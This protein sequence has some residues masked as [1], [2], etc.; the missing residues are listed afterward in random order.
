MKIYQV[1]GCVRD[2]LLGKASK[3]RDWVVVGATSEQMLALG[4]IQVGKDFPVFLHPK[5][6]EEYALARTERKT[7]KGYTGF[8]VHAAPEVTLEEDL[9]R[10]DLTIN[11]IATDETGNLIDPFNGQ[12]DLQAGILRHVSNAFV[13]DPVRVLRVARFAA[14]Y[15]FTIAEDTLT[16]MR[17]MVEN[18][19]VDALVPERVWQETVKALEELHPQRFFEVLRTCGALAQ[20]FPEIDNL[21][22]VPQPAIYHPEIDVGVHTL[23][24][25][26]QARHLTDDT[27]VLFAVLTHDFGKGTTPSNILPGHAGHEMRSVD[28]IKIF[29]QRC[30]VPRYYKA[31]ALAVARYHT[32]CHHL[33]E[34][35]TGT[36]LNALQGLDAFRQPQRFEQF[37]LVCEADAKGR[38]GFENIDYPQANLFR[39]IFALVQ[40]IDIK[41]I[42]AAGWQGSEIAEKLREQ[43]LNII[44]QWKSIER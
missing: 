13:E 20:I 12:A 24:C 10:R 26:Q 14:R 5:T 33:L 21:F 32:H 23:L 1:G 38:Q 22:G 34:L 41:P 7:D 8:Q 6:H 37:L 44:R 11:A 30:C 35:R 28:L 42:I 40:Q 43:R 4:Y 15:N 25:L 39:Q 19:E 2:T 9:K 31:L 18:G 17:T 36:I 29:C 3:D 16:L 27:Q